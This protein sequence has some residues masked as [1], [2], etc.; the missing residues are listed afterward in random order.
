MLYHISRLKDL[1][2]QQL[3]IPSHDRRS[4]D[5]RAA[6]H[7]PPDM[8]KAEALLSDMLKANHVASKDL[9]SFTKAEIKAL[10]YDQL[11][12]VHKFY[13]LNLN[14]HKATVAFHE[15]MR[16]DAMTRRVLM[17]NGFKRFLLAHILFSGLRNTRKYPV[18]LYKIQLI[19]LFSLTNKSKSK[20][21]SRLVRSGEAVI[22]GG[23]T[24][25]GDLVKISKER[26]LICGIN[27]L[28]VSDFPC[29]ISY[30]RGEALLD[31]ERKNKFE[32]FRDTSTFISVKLPLMEGKFTKG[33][34][35]VTT[36]IDLATP[37]GTLNAAPTVCLDL[38]RYG[39]KRIKLV[40]VD[41]N[42]GG[43][44]QDYKPVHSTV[45]NKSLIFGQHP[46]PLQFLIIKSLA[47]Y[48]DVS[49][50]DNPYIR[51]EHSYRHFASVF[52]RQCKTLGKDA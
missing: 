14:V 38:I 11:L 26:D 29:K 30:F 10:S 3:V 13:N 39:V 18:F 28:V 21:Q 50:A 7:Y 41:F 52:A 31:V 36:N 9:S 12:L 4:D 33:C 43:W 22:I 25:H 34:V 8:A 5:L 49:L 46:A 45:V 24:D 20:V 6:L 16:R 32:A 48:Y 47:N 17:R 40:C 51:L 42:L 23:A 19:L 2:L 1:F 37:Y 27:R 35:A 44:R 15:V